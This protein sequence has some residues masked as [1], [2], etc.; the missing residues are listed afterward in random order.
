[1]GTSKFFEKTQLKVSKIFIEINSFAQLNKAT[2]KSSCC[3]VSH[4]KLGN[5][6][7]HVSLTDVPNS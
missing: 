4:P 2:I 3:K 6:G 7:D 5:M 1:L